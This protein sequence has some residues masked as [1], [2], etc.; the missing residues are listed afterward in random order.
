M[1][2]N[3]LLPLAGAAEPDAAACVPEPHSDG[4]PPLLPETA[5]AVGV[6][7]ALPLND[8]AAAEPLA[9]LEL[10]PLPELLRDTDA[11]LLPLI[12]AELLRRIDEDAL[13]VGQEDPVRPTLPLPLPPDGHAVAEALPPLATPLLLLEPDALHEAEGVT[14]GDAESRVVPEATRPVADTDRE[15]EGLTEG[16]ADTEGERLPPPPADAQALTL[17]V[18][19]AVGDF[20]RV[21]E[22]H[23]L[24]VTEP[25]PHLLGLLLEVGVVVLLAQPVPLRPALPLNCIELDVEGELVLL[26]ESCTPGEPVVSGAL[27]LAVPLLL[28]HRLAEGLEEAL[29]QPLPLR[30]GVA[31]GESQCVGEA[32][33]DDDTELLV[34]GQCE[35]VAER[36]GE[37]QLL[38]VLEPEAQLVADKL[39][40][41]EAEA[42]A[43][44]VGQGDGVGLAVGQT[45][46]L[47][48]LVPQG[49]LV[50]DTDTLGEADLVRLGEDEGVGQVEADML[51]AGTVPLPAALRDGVVEAE[52]LAQ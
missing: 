15:A 18:V 6:T 48:E 26:L 46:M 51:T 10:L 5:A 19:Q 28:P 13:V 52:A 17:A 21:L 24:A 4:L 33:C 7:E 50:R 40:H 35:A 49:V 2:V 44:A 45:V 27:W 11:Q 20:V 43:Q 38:A 29:R 3:R 1:C 34:E 14:D 23:G 30:D 41:V 36:L 42:V 22:P 8:A 39:P 31:E 16:D 25:L 37:P 32:L 9:A 12:T 47:A